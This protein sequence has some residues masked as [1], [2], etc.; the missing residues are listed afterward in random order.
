MEIDINELFATIGR[1]Q[2]I[3]ARFERQLDVFEERVRDLEEE[4]A[5]AGLR[6]A[7]PGEES[8]KPDMAPKENGIPPS[9]R[10]GVDPDTLE[11]VFITDEPSVEDATI[12]S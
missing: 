4:A 10:W 5:K 9:G 12:A 8:A 1:Q 3:I 2:V 11:P 6:D 7:G